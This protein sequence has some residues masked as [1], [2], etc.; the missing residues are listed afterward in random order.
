ML[1][2]TNSLTLGVCVFLQQVQ[3]VPGSEGTSEFKKS[4]APLYTK[5]YFF[6]VTNHDDVTS[7]GADPHVV[8]CGPYTYR[9]VHIVCV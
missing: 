7:K 9:S 5:F 4:S 3:L 6:N 8:Q 1:Q 2:N